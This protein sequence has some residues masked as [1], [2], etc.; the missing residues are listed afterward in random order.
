MSPGTVYMSA[1]DMRKGYFLC[2]FPRKVIRILEYLSTQRCLVSGGI[3]TSFIVYV[4][5]EKMARTKFYLGRS[6]KN[7]ERKSQITKHRE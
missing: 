6:R 5:Y 3:N 2:T 7:A 4:L 1:N